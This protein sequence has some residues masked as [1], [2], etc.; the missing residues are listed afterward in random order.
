MCMKKQKI[1]VQPVVSDKRFEVG[2]HILNQWLYLR[3]RG[4]GLKLFFQD[5]LIES[6]AIYG[7]GILGERLFDELKE[8]GITV[9]YGIDRIASSKN[10]PDLKIYS[11]EEET[12]QKI[13]VIVVTP[14]QDYWAITNVLEMKTVA[15]IVSLK[16][17]IDYCR[18]GEEEWA[19]NIRINKRRR[20]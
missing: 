6:V 10:I 16:D 12:F 17:V 1:T 3:Q 18:A 9:K 7:M 15:A 4:K 13:D 14:V 5:N 19:E 8:D 20:F 11:S 2:F